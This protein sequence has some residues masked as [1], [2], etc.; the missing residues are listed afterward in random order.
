[1]QSLQL[2]L[3]L[4]LLSGCACDGGWRNMSDRWCE[5]HQRAAQSWDQENLK[6]HDAGCPTAIFVAPHGELQ[7]CPPQ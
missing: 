2:S 3:I 5:E 6:R 1:M 4:L 7:Q